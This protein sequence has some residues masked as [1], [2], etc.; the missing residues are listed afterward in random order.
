MYK[1]TLTH[2]HTHVRTRIRTRSDEH[3]QNDE[4]AQARCH[5]IVSMSTP[6]LVLT[7]TPTNTRT[8]AHSYA[9]ARSDWNPQ[10]DLQAQAR[11]HRIGQTK[12]VKVYRLLTR[13]TYEQVMFQAAS[14]KLG[15]DQAVLSQGRAAASG[16]LFS[17]KYELYS[18][19]V[20]PHMTVSHVKICEQVKCQGASKKLSQGR[21]AAS[22]DLPLDTRS[23]RST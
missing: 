6:T 16:D 13:K 8:H 5:R 4:R 10:N 1:R 18:T 20:R 22:G 9:H 23:L 12:S 21:A 15:L 17:P 19:S 14:K 7:H 2:A 3:P 11:C